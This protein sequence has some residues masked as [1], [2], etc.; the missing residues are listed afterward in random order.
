[1][2]GLT[3]SCAACRFELRYV[4]ACPGGHD[5]TFPCDEHGHVDM[6]AL[7]EHDRTEYLFARAVVGRD[8]ARPVVVAMA[9][10]DPHPT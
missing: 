1:M 5:Y 6:D 10:P 8:L 4:A 7:N 3:V 2:D 9:A